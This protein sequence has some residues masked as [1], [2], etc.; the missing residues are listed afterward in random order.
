MVVDV[1]ITGFSFQIG[2]ISLINAD[3]T[4]NATTAKYP[5]VVRHFN[6]LLLS[7]MQIS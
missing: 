1:H 2:L 4:Q 3:G 5:F 6:G 7:V